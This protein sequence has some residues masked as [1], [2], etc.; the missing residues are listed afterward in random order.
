MRNV[1]SVILSEK[2]LF[3]GGW[4]LQI[5]VWKLPAAT[6]EPSRAQILAF[7][8]RAGERVIGYDNEAGKGDHRHHRELEE[9]YDFRA[10]DTLIADF[11]ADVLKE[12]ADDRT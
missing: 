8:G 3:S 4:I 12:L 10:L 6:Q 11:T 1:A 9:R 7:L 2:I 5:R